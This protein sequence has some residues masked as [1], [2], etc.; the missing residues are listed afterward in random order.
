MNSFLF[1]C[2]LLNDYTNVL[3]L[4]VVLFIKIAAPLLGTGN[5]GRKES[6]QRETEGAESL[7]V[8]LFNFN[9]LPF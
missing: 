1:S 5:E 3:F 8:T 4:R 7:S 6:G 2:T 9:G